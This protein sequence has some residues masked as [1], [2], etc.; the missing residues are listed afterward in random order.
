M[1]R[2]PKCRRLRKRREFLAVQGSGEKVHTRHFLLLAR[3]DPNSGGRVGI[4]VSKRVGN[5]VARNRVKRMV[6]E[7]ARTTPGFLRPGR[8]VVVVA[9][10]GADSLTSEAVRSDLTRGLRRLPS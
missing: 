5:A 6:R 7:V 10:R 8:D 3:R 1:E 2:F 9:K 4:T